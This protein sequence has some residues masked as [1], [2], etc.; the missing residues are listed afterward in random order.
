MPSRVCAG[1]MMSIFFL[2]MSYALAG[3]ISGTVTV[4]RNMTVPTIYISNTTI[5]QGQSIL[6][7]ANVIGGDSPYTY[8]YQIVNSVTG[9]IITTALVSNSYTTNTFSWTPSPAYAGNTIKANVIVIDSR[10]VSVNSVYSGDSTINAAPSLTLSA[11]TNSIES[12][13]SIVFTVNEMGGTAPFTVEIFDITGNAK[14]GSNALIESQGNGNTVSF[15]VSAP[16]TATYMYNAI[17]TDEGTTTPYVFNSASVSIYIQNT[18]PSGGNGSPSTV[19]GGGGGGPS[20]PMTRTLANGCMLVTNVAVPNGFDVLL[21]GSVASI[22]ESYISSNFTSIIANGRTYV[23]YLGTQTKINSTSIYIE[24]LNVSYSGIVHSASFEAC[25]FP[26][27]IAYATSAIPKVSF[28]SFPVYTELARGSSSTLQMGLK[29]TSSSPETINITIGSGFSNVL[30]LSTKSAYLTPGSGVGIELALTAQPYL[31]STSYVIP[32]Q[33]RI[34][35]NGAIARQNAFITL[36]VLNSTPGEPL[37]LNRISTVNYT[38]SNG[39]IAMGTIA[40]RSPINASLSNASLETILPVSLVQGASQVTTYGIPS[41]ITSR[42]G[43]YSIIWHVP[44]LP[45]NT[46]TYAYYKISN[47]SSTSLP[48]IQDILAVPR[49][50]T[51]RL[52]DIVDIYNISVPI[53]Y[54]GYTNYLSVHAL[55]VGI[56]NG[57]VN[58]T[59]RA[60]N[61]VKIINSTRLVKVTPDQRIDEEFPVVNPSNSG[62]MLLTLSVAAGGAATE[63]TIPVVVSQRNSVTLAGALLWLRDHVL[64]ILIAIAAIALVAVF[65]I[66]RKG[67]R[68][69]SRK[70][71]VSMELSGIKNQIKDNA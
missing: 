58:L 4:L 33:M 68:K 39:V 13:N 31:N 65:A 34:S 17:A 54:T 9:T 36:A 42:G 29:G 26:A 16:I 44:Y 22:T 51:P 57:T 25:S 70:H 60:S 41:N 35:E 45:A 38:G 55:Y 21:N 43:P 47:P 20:G 15:A 2:L 37:I 30:S 24:L 10:P 59:V 67:G 3:S 27:T 69:A 1:I 19:S 48:R 8:D 61:G 50:G 5:D 32:I 46:T 64:Q 18:T 53:F 40:I 71:M 56:G 49:E 28:T 14:M 52:S 12:G 62:T 23:L 66:I 6:L 11:S 7:T 63:Y